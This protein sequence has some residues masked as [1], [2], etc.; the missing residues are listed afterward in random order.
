M[1]SGAVGDDFLPQEENNDSRVTAASQAMAERFIL[2]SF[3]LLNVPFY[4]DWMACLSWR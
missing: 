2:L 3:K 4:K 1:F